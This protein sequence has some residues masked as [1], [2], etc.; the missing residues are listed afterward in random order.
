M[1]QYKLLYLNGRGL[2]EIIRQVDTPFGH[3]PMLEV[4]GK[5]LAQSHA[6]ARYLARQF[7]YAGKNTWEEAL[8]DSIA[9]QYK[10]YI[11]EVKTFYR[12]V[13]G[14]PRWR[15]AD[16]GG[17]AGCRLGYTYKEVPYTL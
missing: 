17:S 3:I 10:D 5:Q 4:D 7:G 14:V 16:V 8:V 6:I 11:E 1:V 13:V 9:S 15:L 12:V 2:G